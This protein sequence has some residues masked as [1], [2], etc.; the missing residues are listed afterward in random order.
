MI[1][2]FGNNIVSSLAADIN[3]TQTAIPVMPGTGEIFAHILT[4]DF[5]NPSNPLPTFAKITLTDEDATVFEVCHLISVSGDTLN[6]I[7]GQEGTTAKGWLLNDAVSNF[8]TRGSENLFVQLS[9]LQS[10]HY[11]AGIAGGSAN[12]LTLELPAAFFINGAVE[13]VL[14]APII[15]YPVA[16][17]TGPATLQLTMGGRVLGT[18]PLRKGD[19]SELAAND[20]LANVA[21]VCLLDA[22]KTF[23]SVV[24]P[25]A[26]YAELDSR[27]LKIASNLSEIATNG[28]TAQQAARDNLD[29]G[30]AATYNYEDF[31]P[32][33]YIPPPT[34]LSNYY[35]KPEADGR[36]EPIDSAWTKEES[37]A[38][39]LQD[40]R[41]GALISVGRDGNGLFVE[42]PGAY[43]SYLQMNYNDS[44]WEPT[45]FYR[46]EVQFFINGAWRTIISSAY[47]TGSNP[48]TAGMVVPEEGV[49]SLVNFQSCTDEFGFPDAVDESGYLWSQAQ[50]KITGNIFIAIDGENVIRQIDAD[51]TA[52]SPNMH[53]IFGLESLPDGCDIS[54]DWVFDG[55]TVLPRTP[56]HKEQVAAAERQKRNL[57]AMATAKIESLQDAIDLNDAT[58]DEKKL[59]LK[60]KAYRLALS[61]IDTSL[62]PDITWPVAPEGEL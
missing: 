16:N 54:G 46:R 2:G 13:W 22:T 56:T 42:S 39:Y 35:T 31:L 30:T 47:R 60:W 57:H 1:T 9:H 17:N 43:D 4:Y 58:H 53:S 48:V 32:S 52:L 25:G 11:T 5:D 3:S 51:S 18:F 55:E 21:L 23:F 19:G 8:A 20:I 33:D 28:A 34:D 26:L 27:Y 40:V 49:S 14:R 12:T 59:L 6:V 44:N 37:D 15:V 38:R 24:N 7:R 36:F 29:L 50:N 61:R 62:A 10:G 45:T 41:Q